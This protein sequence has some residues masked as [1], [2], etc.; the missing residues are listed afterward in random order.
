[1]PSHQKE[2]MQQIRHFNVFTLMI[3]TEFHSR[4][5]SLLICENCLGVK[6]LYLFLKYRIKYLLQEFH[7]M[8]LM[9]F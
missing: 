2:E 1:M 9:F 8:I 3:G 5:F 6:M 4:I 7:V